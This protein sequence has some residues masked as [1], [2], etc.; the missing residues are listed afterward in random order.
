ME[1][2][3]RRGHLGGFSG[4]YN[5]LYYD[6]CGGYTGV[7]TPQSIELHSVICTC[8]VD[9]TALKKHTFKKTQDRSCHTHV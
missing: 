3:I 8:Y 9:Y 7:L 6:L 5:I 4:I 2:K 1:T